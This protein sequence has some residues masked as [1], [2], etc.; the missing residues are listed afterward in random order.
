MCA[1]ACVRACVQGEATDLLFLL[2]E[3]FEFT[4]LQY[5]SARGELRTRAMGD[6]RVREGARVCARRVACER[7]RVCAVVRA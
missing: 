7:R 3:K 2:T 6:A 1:C 5:D 4:V